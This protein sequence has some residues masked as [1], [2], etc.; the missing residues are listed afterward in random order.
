MWFNPRVPLIAT[1]PFL[2]GLAQA[3]IQG[4]VPPKDAVVVFAQLRPAAK[5]VDVLNP[6]T[7]A[8][9][10][11]YRSTR[12]ATRDLTVSPTGVYLGLLELDAGIVE[13]HQYRVSP[14][15]ELIVLDTNGLVVQRIARDVQRY[16]WCG[17]SCLV[18]VIGGSDET[19]LGFHPSGAAISDFVTGQR[20]ALAGPPWPY[21]VT[22]AP[23][24]NSVYL[25]YPGPGGAAQIFRF[26]LPTGPLTLTGHRDLVFSFDGKFYLS[27]GGHPEQRPQ[28]YSSETDRELTLSDLD[29]LGVPV[30]WLPSGSS[31]LLVRPSVPVQK[32]SRPVDPRKTFV[33]TQGGSPPDQDYSVY[34]VATHRVVRSLHGY[35]APWAS[36]PWIVPF[37]SKGRINVIVHP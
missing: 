18:Y 21:E 8:T 24:D 35:F 22:W 31:D 34:D 30:Q 1:M 16:A 9:R 2:A 37:L 28:V 29:R 32:P 11:V 6:V 13:G 5:A 10:T 20:T 25:E 23:F 17:S 7:G 15:S 33:F 36:P 4:Q 19:D 12:W 14:R 27:S 3:G 26:P